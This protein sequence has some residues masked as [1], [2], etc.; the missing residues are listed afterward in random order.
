ML[1]HLQIFRHPN[2]L[3]PN[4]IKL[5]R[6]A[7]SDDNV[8]AQYE[9]VVTDWINTIDIFIKDTAEER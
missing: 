9:E 8:L 4:E 3:V 1:Q 2:T 5:Q 7:A 6:A